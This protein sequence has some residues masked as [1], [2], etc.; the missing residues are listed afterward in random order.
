MTID[1]PPPALGEAN[2]EFG[3]ETARELPTQVAKTPSDGTALPL[4][5]VNVLDLQWVMAGPASTRV[6][7][8]WGA[9]VERV[10]SSHKVETARPIQPFLHDEGGADNGGLYQN[11]N[12]GKMGLALDMSKPESKEVIED[13]V[14][15]ADVVCESFSPKAMQTWGL[16]YEDLKKINPSIIMTSFH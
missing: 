10:E 14:K 15:W 11:M 3:A 13:L 6:L 16:G 4:S 9:T 8:D 1:S 5:D 2:D 12:A 7:A